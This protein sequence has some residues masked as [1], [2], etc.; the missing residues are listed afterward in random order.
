VPEA[1]AIDMEVRTFTI[2]QVVHDRRRRQPDNRKSE[3]ET[4]KFGYYT[5]KSP[6]FTKGDFLCYLYG[7][8]IQE[9]FV[10]I[11]QPD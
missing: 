3:L 2:K 6:F 1:A 8:W 4:D 7:N 11:R 10:F 5:Y 9:Y